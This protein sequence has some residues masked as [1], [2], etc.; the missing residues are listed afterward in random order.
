MFLQNCLTHTGGP[1]R[2]Q[3]DCVNRHSHTLLYVPN[4]AAERLFNK[5]TSTFRVP[6]RARQGREPADSV[7][8]RTAK[9]ACPTSS[10]SCKLK[11]LNSPPWDPR[12]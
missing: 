2:D 10:K 12:R 11:L 3:G 8:E 7:Q 9:L 5:A 6:C 4:V 1:H